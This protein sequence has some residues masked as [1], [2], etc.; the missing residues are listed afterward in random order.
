M[1]R[2]FQDSLDYDAEN[3]VLNPAEFGE[4]ITHYHPDQPKAT[5]AARVMTNDTLKPPEGSG[6]SRVI[7]D[8]DGEQG[9]QLRTW[10]KVRVQ[11]DVDV[12]FMGTRGDHRHSEF[13]F[14][15]GTRWKVVSPYGS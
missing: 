14:A 8:L 10:A 12:A 4:E 5:I 3:V 13:V 1:S 11:K 7:M 9:S 15:D 2:T 6:A